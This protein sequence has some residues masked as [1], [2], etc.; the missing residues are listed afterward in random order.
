M[1]SL[2]I[3][4][5]NLWGNHAPWTERRRLISAEIQRLSADVLAFQEVLR[6]QGP[7]TSQ[8]D[9]LVS[10]Q[11][12]RVCFGRA[13][14]IEK[15][16]VSEFGN[17]L[18]TRFP[19]REQRTLVLPTPP[20][21]ET[22]SALYVVLSVNVGILPV[23]TTHLSWEPEL[24]EVRA[25]QVRHIQQFLHLE[26]SRLPSRVPPH[27]PVLPPILLGDLNAP[28]ESPELVCLQTPTD[29]GGEVLFRDTFDLCGSGPKE[30]F[31]SENPYC[32]ARDPAIDQRIDY[33]LVGQAGA[34]QRLR[35]VSSFVCFRT[36]EGGVF[37]S[38]HF[39]VCTEFECADSPVL[40]SQPFGSGGET[41]TKSGA[42]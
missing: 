26:M 20:S 11:P 18:L 40:P 2:R 24:A 42:A 33:I 3:A 38:D 32:K 4:T 25:A 22:R 14:N 37:P 23:V 29:A 16:F 34:L 8:A 31:S 10:G 19:V 12:F 27:I 7:G 28:W 39:G 5:L 17:A 30:T 36:G 6:P 13:C 41:D 21:A 35:P 9:E 1:F 15:P